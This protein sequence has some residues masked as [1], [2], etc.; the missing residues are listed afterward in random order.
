MSL[1]LSSSF[2][3]AQNEELLIDEHGK[4]IYYESVKAKGA[5]K[6]QLKERLNSFLKKPYKDLKLKTIKG[7]TVFIAAGKL[8]INKTVLVMSHPSGE[9]LYHFQAEIKDEKFRF[10]LT[11]FS[12]VPYQ[13]DRYGNFVSVTN[14][15]VPM[16]NDPG[17]LNEAQ[18]KE[19]QVQTANY[20]SQFAKHFKEYMANKIPQ[21]LA[22]KEKSVVKKDW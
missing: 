5:T 18:W 17:K 10:W 14:K 4:F 9:I 13:R 12:F 22:S 21:A 3:M 15:G 19:Y 20:A 16:E 2:C 6:D 1:L 7:D 8:I 11:D